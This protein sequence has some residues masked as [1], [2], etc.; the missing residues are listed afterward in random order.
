MAKKGAGDWRSP[1]RIRA[2]AAEIARAL[3]TARPGTPVPQPG[4]SLPR[5]LLHAWVGWALCAATMGGLLAV[6]SVGVALAVHAV[7]APVFFALVARHYFRARGARDPLPTALAFV[8]IVALL[9]LVV[10]AGLVL[11]SLAMFGSLAGTWLPFALVFL[12]TWGTGEIMSTLP[13][14][15]PPTKT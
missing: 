4:R 14:K 2:W 7:A 9:D 8:G 11:R 13:W 10:V 15:A 12:A 6:A 5:L 1:E 3:P